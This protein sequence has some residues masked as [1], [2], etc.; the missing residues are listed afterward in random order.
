MDLS[1]NEHFKKFTEREAVI[2][3]ARCLMCKDAPCT[4]ACPASVDVKHF[5]RSIRFENPRHAADIIKDRNVF[6]GVCGT[7]CPHEQLCVGACNN[8]E[9]NIP[10]MIG[11]LQ[12]FAAEQAIG[13]DWEIEVEPIAERDKKVAVIGGGPAGLAAAAKLCSLGYR[14]DIFEKN[15]KLGGVARYGIPSYRLD[16]SV[17]DKEIDFILDL[18]VNVKMNMSLGTDF[19]FDTLFKDGYSAIL[20]A[21]GLS[22]ASTPGL[23]G[24]KFENVL[25]AIDFLSSVN[26]GKEVT[27]GKATV[28]I[29]GGSVAIDAACSALRKGAERVEL[30]CLEGSNE[31]PAFK[32]EI[33]QALEEGVIFHNQNKPVEIVGNENRVIGFKA[34]AVEWIEPNKFIPSN[35]REI[36]GTEFYLRADTI[37]IAIG[38]KPDDGV[39]NSVAELENTRGYLK[40]DEQTFQTSNP[41]IFAAGDIAIGGGKTVV[42][43][44]DDGRRAAVAIDDFLKNN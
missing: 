27:V 20:V 33:D 39:K 10:I 14:T 3:A 9:I 41:K 44:V 40:V 5:I 15:K 26:S 35:A 7:I 11:E 31:M 19:T 28:V 4:E 38:Q 25:T 1:F 36:P 13:N 21:A 30:V 2:E 42:K 43:A 23:S 17:L 37:I 18:G 16:K 34:V 29:G 12:R 24:E 6:A 22:A 8:T 32:K